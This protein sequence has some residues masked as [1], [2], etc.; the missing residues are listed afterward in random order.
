MA[1]SLQMFSVTTAFIEEQGILI[2]ACLGL[3]NFRSVIPCK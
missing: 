2:L 3:R 1:C